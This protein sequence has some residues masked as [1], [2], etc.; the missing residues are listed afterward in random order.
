MIQISKK[1][2]KTQKVTDKESKYR[3]KDRGRRR[4]TEK[5]IQQES[6]YEDQQKLAK[7]IKLNIQN[8]H[9]N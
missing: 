8:K 7:D 4:K 9:K 1:D 2:N 5:G 6:N 3:V